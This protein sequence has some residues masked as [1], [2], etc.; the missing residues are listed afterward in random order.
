MLG[1]FRADALAPELFRPARLS[2]PARLPATLP[3][4]MAKCVDMAMVSSPLAA[5][6][7]VMGGA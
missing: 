4:L 3:R 7:F 5:G 6:E 1:R 2:T